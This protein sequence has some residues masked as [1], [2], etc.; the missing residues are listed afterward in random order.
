MSPAWYLQHIELT[1]VIC[2]VVGALMV[3]NSVAIGD[4]DAPPPLVTV[5]NSSRWRV[6]GSLGTCSST[7]GSGLLWTCGSG[8]P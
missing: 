5:F 3:G 1:L 6:S 7:F 8:F 2:A 4:P